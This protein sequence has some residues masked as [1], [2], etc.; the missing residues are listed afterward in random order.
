[1]KQLAIIRFWYEGNAFSPIKATKE[2]FKNR[3]WISGS[4]AKQFY[5]NTNIELAAVE[6]FLNS[7]PGIEADFI[8]CAAA[9]PG[10]PMQEGLFSEILGY[11][12]E[13]LKARK[14]DGVYLSLHGSA[15]AV[16]EPQPEIT[17]IRRVRELAGKPVPIAVSL[18]LHAN[19]NPEMSKLVD[20]ICGYKTYPHV[21]MLD[22]ATK[23]LNLL[24][25]TM[26]H[27]LSPVTTIVPAGFAPTS[28]KMGTADNPMA[29]LMARARQLEL[30]KN[31]YDVSVFGGFVY[32]DSI[33]TGASVT[34]CAKADATRDAQHLAGIFRTRAP[35]F[36]SSLPSVSEFLAG[37][38]HSLK[39]NPYSRPVAILEP[40]DNIFSGGGADTPGLLRAVLKSG[41]DA[42]SLFAFFCDPDIVQLATKAGPGSNLDC[43]IGGR[44]TSEFGPPV[45][46]T[47]QVEKLTD[48]KFTNSGPM[49]KNLKVELGP[50]VV[51]KAGNLSIVITSENIPVNDR[52][53]FE[54]HDL[55]LNDFAIIYVKAKNHFRSAFDDQFSEIIALETPGPAASDL[56]ALTFKNVPDYML[57]TQIN[58]KYAGIIDAEAIAEIHTSSWRDAYRNIL[59]S[60][61]LDEEIEHERRR[62]WHSKLSHIAE[63]EMVLTI[64]SGE[65]VI[66]FVWI[67]TS[68][69]PG[70]DAVIEAL[71]IEPHNK[72]CGYGKRLLKTTVERL[73]RQGRKSVCLRVFDDNLDAIKFYRHIGGIK[74]QSGIDKFAGS[75]AADSRIGWKDIRQLLSNLE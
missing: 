3:E 4:A 65:L 23:A 32:A 43:R 20:I 12:E 41:I 21:D 14:W 52:A 74:D 69:E 5:R 8:F 1:M 51:L 13:G 46:I 62:F 18:D 27:K 28:F 24:G 56:S 57:N 44:L 22:T 7:N 75:N 48:G 29:N 68:G 53:W 6:N 2:A 54:L 17:L 58:I 64:N 10:G 25:K 31:F 45:E 36:E 39:L 35:Q 34:I 63:D 59:P 40:S 33:D 38:K 42:P 9:Y 50:T 61:Y 73:I 26:A 71:H 37:L 15:I 19:I 30:E 11:I 47:V 55:R 16:E 49:E 67:S 72:G 66:G 60:T 70:Y